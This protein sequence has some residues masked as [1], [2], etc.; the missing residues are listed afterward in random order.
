MGTYKKARNLPGGA[1]NFRTVKK[2]RGPSQK[3]ILTRTQ[4]KQKNP[5]ICEMISFFTTNLLPRFKPAIPLILPYDIRTRLENKEYGEGH[6][7]KGRLR[8]I[9]GHVFLRL[10][11]GFVHQP[12]KVSIH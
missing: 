4:E 5:L 12:N 11:A 10:K 3:K 2:M 1:N 7:R 6:F 8:C 9:N